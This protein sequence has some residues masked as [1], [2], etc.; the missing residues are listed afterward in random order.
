M[1]AN[2]VRDLRPSVFLRCQSLWRIQD[3]PMSPLGLY[4]AEEKN[5]KEEK[6]LSLLLTHP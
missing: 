2:G 6:G 1:A 5:G 3:G 4:L